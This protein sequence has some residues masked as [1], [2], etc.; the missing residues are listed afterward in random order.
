MK[1]N[2]HRETNVEFYQ[3]DRETEIKRRHAHTQRNVTHRETLPLNF[4]QR[5]R[6]A[7]HV[8]VSLWMT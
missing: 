5:V 3:R 7:L 2:T 4:H 1:T 8:Q 6:E